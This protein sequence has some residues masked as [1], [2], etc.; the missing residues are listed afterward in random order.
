MVFLNKAQR[1]ELFHVFNRTPLYERPGD[2]PRGI[3]GATG[4]TPLTYRQFRRW[5]SPGPGCIMV[6]WCGMYLGIEPDG[7]PAHS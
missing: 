4:K 2:G 6:R 5:V 3:Y 7:S 1:R